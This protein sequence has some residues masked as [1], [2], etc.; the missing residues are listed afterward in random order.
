MGF[1]DFLKEC[2]RVLKVTK[3][4]NM[5]DYKTV[6][7]ISSLGIAVIGLMGFFIHISKIIIQN[8]FK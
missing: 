8:I 2:G 3:K 4:P 7:K 6:V 5:K 1:V